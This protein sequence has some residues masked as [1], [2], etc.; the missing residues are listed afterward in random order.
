MVGGFAD[1]WA[2]L[3]ESTGGFAAKI[4]I[5]SAAVLTLLPLI[6]MAGRAVAMLFP[7]DLFRLPIR[8]I[9]TLGGMI[10]GLTKPLFAVASVLT[11]TFSA[12]WKNLQTRLFNVIDHAHNMGR[13]F[14]SIVQRGTVGAFNLLGVGAERLGAGLQKA[15]TLGVGALSRIDAMA[16]SIPWGSMWRGVS[17]G[18]KLAFGGALATATIAYRG[19]A[20]AATAAWPAI[21]GAMKFAALRTDW[22]GLVAAANTSWQRIVQ[23]SSSAASA[24]K[25]AIMPIGGAAWQTWKSIEIGAV[26]AWKI[27]RNTLNPAYLRATWEGIKNPAW[28]A[29]KSIEI[30]A[31]TAWKIVRNTL[32][33]AYL[34][35]TWT[36]VKSSAWQTWKSV[37]IGAVTA[38]KLIRNTM[39]PAYMKATW[40]DMK[41]AALNAWTSIKTRFS[42]LGPQIGAALRTGVNMAWT[43]II[44]AGKATFATLGSLAA[45]TGAMMGRSLRAV[46]G[47]LSGIAGGLAGL[48]MMGGAFA[49]LAPFQTMLIVIPQVMSL[50]GSVGMVV[51]AL[52]SPFGLV[53]GAIVG[54]LA[55]WTRYSET[56]KEALNSVKKAFGPV[57]DT[58][59]DTFGGIKDAMASGDMKLAGQIGMAGL[60]SVF[61][62]GMNGI[63][64]RWGEWAKATVEVFAGAMNQVATLWVTTQGKISKGILSMAESKGVVGDV[65]AKLLGVDI[66]EDKAIDDRKRAQK[67][68]LSEQVRVWTGAKDQAVAQGGSVEFGGQQ[69]TPEEI[70]GWIDTALAKMQQEGYGATDE[71]LKVA[72]PEEAKAAIDQEVQKSLDAIDDM[73]ANAISSYDKFASTAGDSAADAEDELEDLRAEAFNKRQ[74]QEQAR[75]NKELSEKAKDESGVAPG[76]VAPVDDGTGKP[77]TADKGGSPFVGFAELNRKMQEAMLKDTLGNKQLDVAEDSLGVQKDMLAAINEPATVTPPQSQ[78][79]GGAPGG[80]VAPAGGVPAR[81]FDAEIA[82][83][84]AE[85][86]RKQKVFE[87]FRADP[88]NKDPSGN[89]SR[90]AGAEDDRLF[91]DIMSE[92]EKKKALIAEK[93]AAEA[94][95]VQPVASNPAAAQDSG[96]GWDTGDAEETPAEAARRRSRI[97]AESARAVKAKKA[98][99]EA[100]AAKLV[101]AEMPLADLSKLIPEELR[102]VRELAEVPSSRAALEKQYG[103]RIQT[104][105]ELYPDEP[106]P[107]AAPLD[108]TARQHVDAM[109]GPQGTGEG[110][111]GDAAKIAGAILGASGRPITSRKDEEKFANGGIEI[112][113]FGNNGRSDEES[114]NERFAYAMQKQQERQAARGLGQSLQNLFNSGTQTQNAT[115]PNSD[116]AINTAEAN[117]LLGK[118]ITV[119]GDV[120]KKL[121]P[122]TK[123]IVA[124][125]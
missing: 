120:A 84:Q 32:N 2:R 37:Q 43:G 5:G 6:S 112:T 85:A 74:R 82:A 10:G 118:L 11:G 25:A 89:L 100:A 24:V 31:V 51:G 49:F 48:S 75:I 106:Q 62:Q 45:K 81:D 65:M 29:W 44:A 119:M 79:T 95:A 3:N 94:A 46:G 77:V 13:I 55:L 76:D 110:I 8:M 86:D 108:T 73:T 98:A 66:R 68:A 102:K 109:R 104:S 78:V 70:Q 124:G 58:A 19:I 115:D 35:A 22:N 122:Q 103:G 7:M 87:D 105:A 71:Q 28:Q 12:A 61:Y 41:T 80:V 93:A 14:G 34:H 97:R 90:A 26:T 125:A 69:R 1:Q 27:V 83:A 47:G 113:K 64:S 9:G 91:A 39:N 40:V 4:A 123:P 50:L 59:T 92:V 67:Q 20:A 57:W 23:I 21:K 18:A 63:L 54:G 107:A 17:A 114:M 88:A 52:A 15:A 116:V 53:A 101:P 56:G 60:Q 30:G 42:A 99:E 36:D 16:R 111:A 72:G 117:T 96:E 33:P 38:W 121:E